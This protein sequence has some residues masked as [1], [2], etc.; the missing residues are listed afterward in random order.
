[1]VTLLRTAPCS[2][3]LA[4]LFF[5]AIPV[6]RAAAGSSFGDHSYWEER[7]SGKES[8]KT[9]DWYGNWT[10]YRQFLE[11]HTQPSDDVLMV[12]CGNSP[13]SLHMHDAGYSKLVNMDFSKQ[14]IQL[15]SENYPHLQW[16]EANVRKMDDVFPAGSFD[17]AI[18]KG[19][20]DAVRTWKKGKEHKEMLSE[21]SRILRPGGRYLVMTFGTPQQVNNE[22]FLQNS[23]YAWDVQHSEI[24]KPW[25]KSKEAEYHHLYVCTKHGGKN[26]L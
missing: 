5:S 9:F 23:S 2:L 13:L 26:E 25:S 15:M 16:K 1:M 20:F 24:L 14:V 21:I 18:D 10:H 6:S 8:N 7:Y 4:A 19:T 3:Y 11:K 22:W 12:G 17:V